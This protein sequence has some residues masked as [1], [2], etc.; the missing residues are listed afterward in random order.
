MNNAD[1]QWYAVYTRSRHEKT[2]ASRLEEKRIEVFLPLRKVLRRWKDRRKE[3]L[4]PLFSS[5]VFVRI[6]FTQKLSVLQT[7]G[8]VQI[9]SEGSKPMP[10]PEEQ[11]VS[12]QK[13]VESGLTYDP[14]PYLKEGSLVSVV[15]GPLTGVQGILVEKR[16]KHLLVLSVDLIQQSAAL[17]VDISDTDVAGM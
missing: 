15:R 8:V 11:I 1:L 13:L 5:Y 16:K 10:I 2:V 14:Y 3:V 7:P 17:Q 9:L 4:M 6:P 12:I